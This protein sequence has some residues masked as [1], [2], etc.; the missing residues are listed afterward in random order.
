MQKPDK[1]PV[2]YMFDGV[3]ENVIKNDDGSTLI[4]LR[5]NSNVNYDILDLYGQQIE[6]AVKKIKAKKSVNA[7]NYCWELCAQI[8]AATYLGSTDVYKEAIRQ[9]GIYKDYEINEEDVK[10]LDKT[11]SEFGLGWFTEKVDNAS[12]NKI[13]LRC[14]YGTSSYNSAQ[15][16]M[17]INYLTEE[18]NDLGLT[19]LS[20]R[21]K[22]ELINNWTAV[23]EV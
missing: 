9:R 21:K 19:T 17:V 18:A 7:N 2:G 23:T 16:G 6:C 15:L 8:A 22:N 10:G 11:W 5:T 4:T 14:Y 20:T 12:D 3:L 13:I 1:T